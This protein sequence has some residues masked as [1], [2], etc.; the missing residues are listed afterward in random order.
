MISEAIRTQWDLLS[1]ALALG[2]QTVRVGFRRPWRWKEILQA[3]VQIGV[4]SLPII[5]IATAFAG[6]VV[7][8]EIAWHMDEAL[9]T[10]SMIPGFTG[11]FIIRELG[12]AIPSLLLVA[13]VGAAITAEVGSMKITEQI[14]ALKLLRIDPVGYL[15]FPRL[16]ACIFSTACLTLI[17]IA[18]TLSCAVWMAMVRY[19]F[20]SWNI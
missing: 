12:I 17:S 6:L 10:T 11:Q 20:S 14:D 1:E 7:T 4:E 19:N 15:V 3:T 16:V 13:K 2:V 8:N 18:V 5:T 9:H